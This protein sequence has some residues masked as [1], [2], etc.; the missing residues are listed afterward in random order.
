LIK[1]NAIN[2]QW[3][4][5]RINHILHIIDTNGKI[6]SKQN[7]ENKYSINIKAME[8]NSIIHSIP[9]PWKQKLKNQTSTILGTKLDNHCNI[10]INNKYQNINEICTKD[11]LD[12][13][14][15]KPPTSKKRWIE[16][17]DDM[18]VDESFWQ[19]IYQTPFQLT[20]NSKILMVQYKLIHRILAVNH[21]LKKWKRINNST[22]NL[23]SEEDTIEHFIYH[24]PDTMK[25]WESIMNWW[26]SEFEFTIP[27][28]ILEVLFGIQNELYNNYLNLLNAVMLHAKYYIYY[29]KKK[30]EK[31]E[32]YNYLLSLK[33]KKLYYKENNRRHIFNNIWQELY[34]NIF[35]MRVGG[36][37]HIYTILFGP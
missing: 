15:S 2:V 10:K 9:K 37:K 14:K 30:E 22:C 31:I 5:A 6:R 1:K 33:L 26:R 25:L 12:K 27:I 36:F 32:L 13:D 21:N 17:Y 11:I 34:S 4:Q 24:C 23:C 20:K 18:N 28:S 7:I 3:K 29:A 8:Y 16:L 19:K 35:H